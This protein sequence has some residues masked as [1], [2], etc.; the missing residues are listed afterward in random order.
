MARFFIGMSSVHGNANGLSSFL[1]EELAL[2][3]RLGNPDFA[4]V[5]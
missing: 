5:L 4:I 1:D 2:A 3:L